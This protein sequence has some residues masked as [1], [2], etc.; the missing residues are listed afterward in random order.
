MYLTKL[1]L[2][3]GSGAARRD[4]ANPYEMHRTLT[5]AF[6]WDAQATPEKFLWRLESAAQ[7]MDAP[8]LLVQSAVAA[9]WLR[10]QEATPGYLID[11]ATKRVPL[12]D[13]LV[14]GGG[15]RFRIH[16]N[17]TVC[18]AGKRVGL[19]DDGAL[20]EWLRRQCAKAGSELKDAVIAS[21]QRIH[22]RKPKS[23]ITLQAVGFE[24]S[25]VVRDCDAMGA[26]L[27]HGVGHAKAFGFGMLS[28]AP[29]V[30]RA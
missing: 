18:R 27:R 22:M 10:V 17:P 11:F 12:D 28:L 6:A 14:A 8:T 5:R 30:M 7:P 26:A 25:M 13:L 24:G 15:Y 23:V 16:A 20:L 19:A 9:N 3:S 21:K 29:L 1:T 2:D 4:L